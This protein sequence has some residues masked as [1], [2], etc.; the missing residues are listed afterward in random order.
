MSKSNRRKRSGGELLKKVKPIWEKSGTYILGV[1][2]FLLT[3]LS[4]AETV[5]PVALC[6]VAAA[7]VLWEGYRG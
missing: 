6:L 5:K 4:S 3:C 1:L 7:V 2:F